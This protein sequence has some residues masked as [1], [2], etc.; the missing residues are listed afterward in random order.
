MRTGYNVR[1]P[2]GAG[3]VLFLIPLWADWLIHSAKVVHA[4]AFGSVVILGRVR[5]QLGSRELHRLSDTPFP[6]YR[7]ISGPPIASTFA[8]GPSARAES[9]I[10]ILGIAEPRA[11]GLIAINP[12]R[13]IG[14]GG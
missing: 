9:R 3:S 13:N 1:V 11:S 8:G 4:A 2:Q 14:M 10:R 5:N 12:G 6:A 7:A